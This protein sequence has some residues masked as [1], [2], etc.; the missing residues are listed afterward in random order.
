[1]LISLVTLAGFNF[2]CELYEYKTWPVFC[3]IKMQEPQSK[4][5]GF[6][7]QIYS[8]LMRIVQVRE[9]WGKWGKI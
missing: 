5:N 8:L 7:H 6:E 1:M 2:S 3:S 9:K 4:F